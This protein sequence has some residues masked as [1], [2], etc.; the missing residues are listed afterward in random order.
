MAERHNLKAEQ[1][2]VTEELTAAAEAW[3][4]K[5]EEHWQREWLSQVR[6]KTSHPKR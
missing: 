5:I 4:A 2:E 3:R 1:P 6:T